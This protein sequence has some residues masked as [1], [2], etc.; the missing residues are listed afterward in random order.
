MQYAVSPS[1]RFHATRATLASGVAVVAIGAITVSPVN[2]VASIEHRAEVTA[3]HVSTAAVELT[4]T[5]LDIY[6]QAINTA[7]TNISKMLT[8]QQTAGA[9]PVV[10]QIAKNQMA[11]LS[12][13]SA[14]LGPVA[15][16]LVTSI[17]AMPTQLQAALTS[18]SQGDIQGGIN[19]LMEA[20]AAPLG[21]ALNLGGALPKALTTLIYQ[22][23]TNL[24]NVVK[25]IPNLVVSIGTAAL[26]PVNG[27]IGGIGAGL[28][29][30]ANAAM[31]G[32]F[33]GA[34]NA[35]VAA[36]GYALDGLLNGG[37]GPNM[38]PLVG[39]AVPNGS[40]LGGGL[41]NA[42]ASLVIAD[43]KVT[44]TMPGTFGSI[45]NA[46]NNIIKPAILPVKVASDTVEV[47]ATI[48]PTTGGAATVA[49][50]QAPVT[51]SAVSDQVSVPAALAAS[52]TATAATVSEQ[53]SV[54]AA[55]AAPATTA[56][57]SAK[58]SSSTADTP[59]PAGSDAAATT[60]ALSSTAADSTD[61]SST[62][63]TRGKGKLKAASPLTESTDGSAA[64]STTVKLK[65]KSATAAA[66]SSTTESAAAEGS[67]SDN[68]KSEG[69]NSDAA[70]PNTGRH[71]AKDSSGGKDTSGAKAK[72]SGSTGKRG[73]HAA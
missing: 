2:P 42:A 69:T 25:Q 45:Q 64:G 41:L 55:V 18:V 1:T 39:A 9:V 65:P 5:A 48:A 29:K 71:T 4:A 34:L 56:T 11:A 12:N 30:I 72:S 7:A 6:G 31:A 8:A 53:V 13:L 37:Y 36:P 73:R 22:P 14:A 58:A 43:G 21:A 61:S 26:G 27:G 60:K 54:P 50:T 15:T 32:D 38:G 51:A 66:E 35:V 47:P 28:Q 19:Q 49:S 63:R 46:I 16:N 68:A 59:A 40:V 67:K 44:M 23:L 3:Q 17:G 52:P 10:N 70:K 57:A 24:A 33:T 62:A 20:V